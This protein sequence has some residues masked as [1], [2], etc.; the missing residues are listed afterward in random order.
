M[1]GVARGCGWQNKA[2]VVNLATFYFIGMSIAVL[3]A[4]K[5]NL[6]AKVEFIMNCLFS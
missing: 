2:V 3:L 6:Q 5:L 4:F 1:S